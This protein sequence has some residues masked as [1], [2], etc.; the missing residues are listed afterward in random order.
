MCGFGYLD[1]ERTDRAARGG[2]FLIG[3]DGRLHAPHSERYRR[4]ARVREELRYACEPVVF[5]A[6]TGHVVLSDHPS[7][8]RATRPRSM[9]RSA[10]ATPASSQ[11][12]P[13][14]IASRSARS[15]CA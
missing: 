5:T 15:S 4:Q 8:P 12:S 10:A 9:R 6:R 2:A 1:L 13:L 7:I 3:L 14:E 11:T